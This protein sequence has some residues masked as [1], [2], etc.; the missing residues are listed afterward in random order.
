MNFG[1]WVGWGLA[2]A[3]IAVGFAAYGWQGAVLGLTVA[4]FWLLLQ[5]SRAVRVLRMAGQAPVGHVDS[6]V[7]LHAR[8]RPGMTM[9]QLIVLTRSLG[10]RIGDQPEVWRWSDGAASVVVTMGP[11]G[12]AQWRLDRMPDPTIDPATRCG[13]SETKNPAEAGS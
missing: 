7:M 4:V 12:I 6:A 8:L 3:A 5:F 11:V 2:V 9:M 1:P 10:E 13:D